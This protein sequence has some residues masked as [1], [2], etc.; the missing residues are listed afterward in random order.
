M[1]K[2]LEFT[3]EIQEA[4]NY[5]GCTCAIMRRLA[6]RQHMTILT[7]QPLWVKDV[8]QAIIAF[9]FVEQVG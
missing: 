5:N 3:S 4:L 6:R 7:A 8:H 9:L 2:R 1:T